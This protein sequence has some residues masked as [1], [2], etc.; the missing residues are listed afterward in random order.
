MTAPTWRDDVALASAVA[1]HMFAVVGVEAAHRAPARARFCR[2]MCASRALIHR[3]ARMRS[4]VIPPRPA[5]H[6][7]SGGGRWRCMQRNR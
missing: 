4:C 1:T 7:D 2:E 6:H 5:P 3:D